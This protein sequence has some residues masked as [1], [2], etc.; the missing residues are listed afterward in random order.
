M[1]HETVFAK[2]TR[3]NSITA[4]LC[5]RMSSNMLS[6]LTRL[7]QVAL[8]QQQTLEDE[9]HKIISQKEA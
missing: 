9:A 4:D 2:E 6:V 3:K 1:R 8:E 7:I 5:Y